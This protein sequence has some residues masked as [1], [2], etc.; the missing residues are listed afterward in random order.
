MVPRPADSSPDI[1]SLADLCLGYLAEHPEELVGFMQTVGYDPNSL[2]RAVGSS[3]FQRG[4][5]DYFASNEPILLAFCANA[6]LTPESFMRAWYKLN[7]A[8]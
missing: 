4:V 1:A 8:G 6:N 3:Q 7:P 2:R 5:I